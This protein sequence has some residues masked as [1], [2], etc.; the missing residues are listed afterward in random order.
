METNTNIKA[1][2]R[3]KVV[4]LIVLAC[5]DIFFFLLLLI[6][7]DLRDNIIINPTLRFICIFMWISMIISFVFLIIDFNLIRKI[8]VDS[9]HL[10]QLA[11]LDDLTSIP[12]R[13][14][15][16][17]M[18]KVYNTPE[19][20]ADI[21]CFVLSI[22]NLQAVNE[23]DGREQGDIMLQD[24]CHIFEGVGDDYGFVGRN[25]GNEFVLLMEHGTADKLQ[26]F[27]DSLQSK[28][29]EYNG[30][31]ENISLQITSACTLNSQTHISSLGKLLAFTLAKLPKSH[32]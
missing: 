4:Q 13:A 32:L 28:L 14:S 11:Y 20:L 17:I 10:N 29:D 26:K 6:N 22:S 16:D 8:T 25:G 30:G 27:T 23:K 9:H 18:F 31:N 3:S 5:I 24:F 19:S 1:I 2:Y 12:N 21:G 7:K 15:L